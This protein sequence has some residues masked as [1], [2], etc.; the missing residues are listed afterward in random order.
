MWILWPALG[1]EFGGQKPK[2]HSEMP[3]RCK[4]TETEEVGAP[5]GKGRGH[6]MTPS[7]RG[8]CLGSGCACGW[9]WMV[10]MVRMYLMPLNCALKNGSTGHF[11]ITYIICSMNI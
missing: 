10:A 3:R 8:V 7:G 1:K 5:W 9:K 11:H 6:G 2:Y 4:F